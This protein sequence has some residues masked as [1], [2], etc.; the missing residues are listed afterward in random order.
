M[1]DGLLSS[2]G[3]RGERRKHRTE[4]RNQK[5]HRGHDALYYS[6]PATSV[7][8]RWPCVPQSRDDTRAY[9]RP[10]SKEPPQPLPR[11]DTCS[12]N[13]T[14]ECL[15]TDGHHRREAAKDITRA[16]CD[17]ARS[18]DRRPFRQASIRSQTT[19]IDNIM[20]AIDR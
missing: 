15:A 7:I 2:R 1:Q 19:D 20:T 4:G 10:R 18:P 3:Q 14:V 16:L 12:L 11:T 17:M 6:E 13:D 8:S 9:Y 5:K